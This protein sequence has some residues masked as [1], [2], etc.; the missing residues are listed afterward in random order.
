MVNK[1]VYLIKPDGTVGY[2]FQVG[3]LKTIGMP[4]DLDLDLEARKAA[5]ED[6]AGT[7]EEIATWQLSVP[8]EP[9]DEAAERSSF[10]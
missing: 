4:S 5:L 7:E 2:V 10:I 3:L 6:G 9:P 1:E 8:E